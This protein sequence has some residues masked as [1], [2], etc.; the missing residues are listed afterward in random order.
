MPPKQQLPVKKGQPNLFSFF[1]KPA[2]STSSQP[3]SDSSSVQANTTPSH[4][5]GKSSTESV[6]HPDSAATSKAGDSPFSALSS[7]GSQQTHHETNETSFQKGSRD[8]SE[9][10][11][12]RNLGI[13]EKGIIITSFIIH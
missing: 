3:S 12:N 8:F 13:V 11:V 9:I 1:S 5:V 2:V 10:G 7:Q 6:K 4:T